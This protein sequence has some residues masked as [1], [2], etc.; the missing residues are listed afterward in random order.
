MALRTGFVDDAA[1]KLNSDITCNEEA[2]VKTTLSDIKNLFLLLQG[3]K[4]SI[5]DLDKVD[6]L[7]IFPRARIANR[8]G[9]PGAFGGAC[10]Y[11]VTGLPLAF[12]LGNA[13]MCELIM[14]SYNRIT[15]PICEQLLTLLDKA[16]ESYTDKS[17]KQ[18]IKNVVAMYRKAIA[19]T[20]EKNI[21]VALALEQLRI[22]FPN[23]PGLDPFIDAS[24]VAELEYDNPQLAEKLLAIMKFRHALLERMGASYP[25]Y[26]EVLN[27]GRKNQAPLVR[28]RRMELAIRDKE[29][30]EKEQADERARLTEIRATI[31]KKKEEERIAKEAQAKVDAEKNA[32]AASV[33]EKNAEAE[34]A[35]EKIT[36]EE[37]RKLA[38]QREQE[39]REARRK[40]DAEALAQRQ[41]EFKRQAEEATQEKAREEAGI[42]A[43]IKALVERE[44]KQNADEV[45][46]VKQELQTLQAASHA[47]RAEITTFNN[48]KNTMLA[49]GFAP[50]C[51]EI[52]EH[53]KDV[54]DRWTIRA[55]RRT[56]KTN[57]LAFVRQL[58][59]TADLDELEKFIT[60]IKGGK[61]TYSQGGKNFEPSLAFSR[62]YTNYSGTEEIILKAETKVREAKARIAYENKKFS[63]RAEAMTRQQASYEA[64]LQALATERQ[65]APARLPAL[66]R[67]ARETYLQ[68]QEQIKQNE[69]EELRRQAIAQRLEAIRIKEAASVPPSRFAPAA[70]ERPIVQQPPPPRAFG[71]LRDTVASFGAF[72]ARPPGQGL[73]AT[74]NPPP[75]PIGSFNDPFASFD[76]FPS[77]LPGSLFATNNPP[78]QPPGPPRPDYFSDPF[79]SRES[80][81]ER[82]DVFASWRSKA[83]PGL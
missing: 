61:E 52:S 75:M 3:G 21:G 69:R 64:R 67:Q 34:K 4:T 25:N 7:G 59:Q 27:K 19:N 53:I 11:R 12:G 13:A 45:A 79:F 81:R 83:T 1:C 74:N 17:D 77:L 65:Q 41:A 57:A 40:A 23:S 50:L 36:K 22:E 38:A 39:A 42:Q 60:N 2:K 37:E 32:Q 9:D 26:V 71:D 63:D 76:A 70:S 5:F 28:T 48:D 15:K 44:A 35:A 58:C 68:Q 56:A 78:P 51:T 31:A 72:P 30:R 20:N 14:E 54:T 80:T 73:F 6:K 8:P 47:L 55:A 18:Q 62:G 16:S 29:R 49:R 43:A 82:D 66:E 24:K 46:N 33:M 10:I